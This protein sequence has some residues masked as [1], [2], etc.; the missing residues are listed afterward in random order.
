[1]DD[2]CGTVTPVVSLPHDSV[3]VWLSKPLPMAWRT[4]GNASSPIPACAPAETITSYACQNTLCFS[5]RRFD[6][7]WQ[8]ATLGRNQNECCRY[9]SRRTSEYGNGGRA[10]VLRL[11]TAFGAYWPRI[12]SSHFCA[13][14]LCLNCALVPVPDASKNA[15]RSNSSNSL[16]LA[17][18]TSSSG[19]W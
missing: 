16:A 18:A 7:A 6:M 2:H 8:A 3:M 13:S 19:I 15:L 17:I 11:S 1:M 12:M 5:A 14:L 10:P 4:G 9:G